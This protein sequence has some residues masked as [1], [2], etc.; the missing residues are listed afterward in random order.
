MND[1]VIVTQLTQAGDVIGD[2]PPEWVTY[3]AGKLAR[4]S[5]MAVRIFV[6]KLI[7]NRHVTDQNLA[8]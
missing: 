1:D 2:L 3:L 4:S 5:P 6:A 7:L 8:P